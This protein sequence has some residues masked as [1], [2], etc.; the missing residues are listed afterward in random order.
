[1]EVSSIQSG[2]LIFPDVVSLYRGNKTSCTI[3]IIL[4]AQGS[5][6]ALNVSLQFPWVLLFILQKYSLRFQFGY[7]ETCLDCLPLLISIIKRRPYVTFF[8]LNVAVFPW[9]HGHLC[10]SVSSVFVH[11]QTY[12]EVLS[13]LL[14]AC[15]NSW[16]A[17]CLSV[18][19]SGSFP[20]ASLLSPSFLCEY[21]IRVA[22]ILIGLL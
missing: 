2:D 5:T 18:S 4:I 6:I 20:Q 11:E 12:F 1:M 10:G 7:I 8:F 22:C 16:L 14:S 9:R 19:L 15:L 21:L 3:N 17:G 13:L